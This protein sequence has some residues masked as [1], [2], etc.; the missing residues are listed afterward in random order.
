MKST[1]FL[2]LAVS[3]WIGSYLWQQPDTR[4]RTGTTD[5]TTQPLQ[6]RTNDRGDDLFASWLLTG[7][8]N[9]IAL[10]ELAQRKAQD[11]EVKRFAEMMVKDHRE[12]A[13]KLQP[14]ASGNESVAKRDP[15]A[16]LPK[17]PG[18]GGQTERERPLPEGSGV[19]EASFPH[20]NIQM[21]ALVEELGAQ[22]L[23]SAKGTLEQKQGADFDRCYIGMALGAHHATK[24][25]MTVFQRH[26]S[27]EL[28]KLL[29]DGQRTVST[30][31]EHAQR[32]AKML[33]ERGTSTARA[34]P[35]GENRNPDKDE[36]QN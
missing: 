36:N 24:D 17:E 11:P 15:A 18:P 5:E 16:D 29:A 2:A 12:M 10:A 35:P 14:F 13:N 26:A 7:N 9:E 19:R 27:P 30:H 33:E 31:L 21:V 4:Q 34:M 28:A 3:A 22:C 32:L 1:L 20:G 23:E 6:Q 8:N 25:M